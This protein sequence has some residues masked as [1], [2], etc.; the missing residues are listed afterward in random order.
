M[1]VDDLIPPSFS[2]T[3]KQP[4]IDYPKIHQIPSVSLMLFE[5]PKNVTTS[6]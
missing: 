5:V 1:D 6:Y 3:T 4:L 2:L